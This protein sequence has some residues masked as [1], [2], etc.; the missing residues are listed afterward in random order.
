MPD[1]RWIDG[2]IVGFDLETTGLDREIEEPVSYAFATYGSGTLTD[3]DEGWIMPSR[4]ISPG[5]TQVHG[6]DKEKLAEHSAVPLTEGISH[7]TRRLLELSSVGTPIVGANLAYDLTMVDRCMR[8]LRPPGSLGASSWHG[9]VL[10]VLVLDRAVDR[11]FSNRPVRKLSALCEHYG[12]RAEMHTAGGDAIAAVEVLLAQYSRFEDLQAM[13]LVSL[14][15]AQVEWH[16]E[17]C[18]SL[19]AY[20]R[21]KGRSPLDAGEAAWPYLRERDPGGDLRLFEP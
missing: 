13:D 16:K 14:H 20:R 10:D 7:I 3:L 6:M 11:D 12:V 19:S 2:P 8:R 17:W 18:E 9:P 1:A 4:Q 5:A 21:S 15:E